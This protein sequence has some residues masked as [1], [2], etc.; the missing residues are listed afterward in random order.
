MFGLS[1]GFK[2]QATEI[3]LP[4]LPLRGL[5]KAKAYKQKATLRAIFAALALLITSLSPALS[6]SFSEPEFCEMACCVAQGHCCCAARKPWV[7]GQNPSDHPTIGPVE[8]K[9]QSCY[10]CAPPSSSHVISR[11]FARP[12]AHDFDLA[13]RH[14]ATYHNPP[15]G[16]HFIWSTPTPPRAPPALFI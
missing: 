8:I 1:C 15:L 16:R 10:S 5:M 12:A 4:H 3:L 6:L 9:S 2:K 11:E 7:K 13:L 14:T